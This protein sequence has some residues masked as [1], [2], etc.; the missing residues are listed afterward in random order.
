MKWIAMIGLV[1][2]L[3]L[4]FSGTACAADPAAPGWMTILPTSE[5]RE[6]LA[7]LGTGHEAYTGLGDATIVQCGAGFIEKLKKKTPSP[8]MTELQPGERLWLLTTK[9]PAFREIKFPGVRVLWKG[10]GFRVL[11]ATETGQMG[12]AAK[13]SDFSRLEPLPANETILTPLRRAAWKSR[14]REPIDDLLGR[15]DRDAFVADLQA[16]VD[17]KTRYTYAEGANRALEH[18]EKVF[19]DLGLATRRLPFTSGATPRDNLEAFL[20][21]TDAAAAG[22][23]VVLGHLDSTSEKAATLAPGADDNGSG[24]AGVL[25]LAR[26]MTKPGVTSR[27]NL[28]FLLVLGEEQ[29]LL[30]SKAYVAGLKPE[31]LSRIRAVI[32]M[33]M[34]GFD[35]KPPLSLLIETASFNAAMAEKAAEL[36]GRHTTLATQISY[37][38]WGSD[39]VPFLNKKVPTLLTIESE[40]DDNP[41]YHRTTDLVGAMNLDLCYQILRLNAALLAEYA[42]AQAPAPGPTPGEGAARHR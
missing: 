11:A 9:D 36:A 20:P 18:C 42:G 40:F 12:L 32:N 28:R 7:T 1:A 41:N 37:R 14:P 13:M 4:I 3:G 15:L 22:E 2:L 35:R 38:P 26:L 21:G 30:G 34:I 8:V 5:A 6:I 24:A 10:S 16:L 39:H 27:A 23:V 25:A 31:D 19:R 29:G 33:D 17:L